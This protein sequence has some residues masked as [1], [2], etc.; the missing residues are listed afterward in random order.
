MDDFAKVLSK[1]DIVVLADIYAAREKDTLGIS[2][3][4]I[5]SLIN[6][7]HKK[8]FYFPTFDEIESFV[9]SHLNE[10]DICITMGAG[11]IYKLGEDILGI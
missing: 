11:D 2:S 3:K 9:L 1:A 5:E 10:G 7:E 8:A 6:K 4:D